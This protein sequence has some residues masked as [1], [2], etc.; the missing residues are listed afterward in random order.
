MTSDLS[1]ESFVS[2]ADQVREATAKSMQAWKEGTTTLT[3]Q[4]V[5]ML[6]IPVVDLTKPMELYLEN[7]QRTIDLQREMT[8]VWTDLLAQLSGSLREQANSLHHS[9]V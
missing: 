1:T 8:C 7:I 9:P 5:T 6:S 3:E 2:V 4:V